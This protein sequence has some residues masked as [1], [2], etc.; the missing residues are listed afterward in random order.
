MDTFWQVFIEN[1]P[2]YVVPILIVAAAELAN[3]VI[4]KR[5]DKREQGKKR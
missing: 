2:G 4:F 5:L 3:I 1:W